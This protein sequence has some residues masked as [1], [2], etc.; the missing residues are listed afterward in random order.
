MS[1]QTTDQA[2]RTITPAE[3]DLAERS[4]LVLHTVI[5]NPP[6]I[7]ERPISPSQSSIAFSGIAGP[8]A[9]EQSVFEGN[10]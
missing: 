2:A 9:V 7:R 4:G 1:M 5:N 8:V 10:Q 6:Q 3:W